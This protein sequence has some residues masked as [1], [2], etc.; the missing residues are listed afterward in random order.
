MLYI[1]KFS[2]VFNYNFIKLFL[3]VARDIYTSICHFCHIDVYLRE[4]ERVTCIHKIHVTC[5]AVV[6]KVF[7]LR[8]T[9]RITIFFFTPMLLLVC[10]F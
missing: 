6:L 2:T 7:T 10:F 1:L 4:K 8:H 9:L 5:S 3:R